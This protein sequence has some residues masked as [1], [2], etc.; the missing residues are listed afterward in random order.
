[1][2]LV[3][4]IPI[5]GRI[6]LHKE[7]PVLIELCIWRPMHI[8]VDLYQSVSVKLGALRNCYID[9]MLIFLDKIFIRVDSVL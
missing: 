3:L 9:Q 2:S 1:M 6:V 7:Y 5:L 4:A 8:G